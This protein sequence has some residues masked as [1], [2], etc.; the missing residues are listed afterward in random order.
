MILDIIFIALALV[1]LFIGYKIGVFRIALKIASFFSGLLIA[2][3][4]T[5]PI[6]NLTFSWGL[7]QGFSDHFYEKIVSNEI[8][9]AYDAAGGGQAGYQALFE[10]FGFP[11]FVAKIFAGM[12]ADNVGEDAAQISRMAADGIAK[13][14]LGIIVFFALLLLSSIIIAILKKSFKEIRDNVFIIRLIDGILGMAV[15]AVILLIIVYIFLAIMEKNIDSTS[16]FTVWIRT[17]LSLDTEDF[18]IM[19]YF[20]THNIIAN[21]FKML[22]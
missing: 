10:N 22:F 16:G 20:Y 13:V 9:Q 7:G 18:R 11:G 4:L 14:I 8:Y 2:I 21:I 12:V 5:R 6:T 3:F 19:K 17:Q 1:F 15:F